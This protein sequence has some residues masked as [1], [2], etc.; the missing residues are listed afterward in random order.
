MIFL[1]RIFVFVVVLGSFIGPVC[2][3]EPDLPKIPAAL[4][5][6]VDRGAQA[7]FLGRKFGL[8][9]WITIYQGQ[10]QYYYITPDQKGFVMGILFDE[11]GKMATVDQVRALQKQGDSEILDFLAADSSKPKEITSVTDKFEYKTPAEKMFADVENSNWLRLGN[12]DAPAVYVF[13][14]PQC[15]HCHAFM[16]DLRKDYIEKGLIQVRLIP[17]GFRPETLAQAAFLLAS[18]NPQERWFKHLE[19]DES[20][21]PA[22]MD[23]STQGVQ[24]NLALMQAWKFTVTPLTTY[25]SRN[26]EVKIVRGRAKDVS[27]ILADLAP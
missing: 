19:G 22:A 5:G 16:D 20:A 23:I 4:Q 1:I 7:R 18:P 10:E 25:R 14:D 3:Q 9:G 24:K 13:V 8:D 17:V 12:E 26:G 2:A 6:L 15:P 21:L 11:N 27:Q